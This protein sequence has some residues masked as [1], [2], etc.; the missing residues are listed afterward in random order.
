MLKPRM[1]MK[2]MPRIGSSRKN[3]ARCIASANRALR[4]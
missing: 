1:S 2:V 3:I 4:G